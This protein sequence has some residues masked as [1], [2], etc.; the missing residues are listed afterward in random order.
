M[1]L[2][3]PLRVVL[4]DR[5]SKTFPSDVALPGRGDGLEV[6][7]VGGCGQIRRLERRVGDGDAD[8]ATVKWTGWAGG[9][10]AA[11]VLSR[12][13][14]RTGRAGEGG[15][16]GA[17]ALLRERAAVKRTEQPREGGAEGGRALSRDRVRPVGRA[18]EG[19]CL[20][21]TL[22]AVD[23]VW[24]RVCQRKELSLLT[25]RL[26]GARFIILWLCRSAMR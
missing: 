2:P 19:G 23:F 6:G 25:F 15:A 9:A 24:F 18:E 7:D 12:E 14:A 13:W 22:I 1:A 10:E 16:E 11:K 5:W 17:G 8:G 26:R 21:W 3:F 4:P 20:S